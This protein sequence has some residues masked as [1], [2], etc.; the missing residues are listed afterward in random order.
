MAKVSSYIFDIRLLPFNDGAY[1]MH[2]LVPNVVN[3]EHFI[4]SFFN[5]SEKICSD[6]GI[7]IDSRQGTHMQVFFKRSVSHRMY[8]GFSMDTRP[9]GIFKRHYTAV[10]S[11]LF[12][13][14]IARKEVCEYGKA[15]YFT[16]RQRE[17]RI[18]FNYCTTNGILLCLSNGRKRYVRLA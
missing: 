4:F 3:D 9:R 14:V 13:V 15:K 11:Q 17:K 7:M 8:S 10:A 2:K 1:P 6:I 18:P 5:F 12:R 16:I